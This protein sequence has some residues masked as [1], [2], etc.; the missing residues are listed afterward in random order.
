MSVTV[1]LADDHP[2]VRQGMRNLLNTEADFS[3]V[4]EAKNGLEAV[5]LGEQLRPDIMIVD[6]MMPHLNGL[7]VLRQLTGRLPNTRFIVLSMQSADPYVLQAL[8]AGASGYVLKDS[9]PEELIHAIRQVLNGNRYLSPQLNERMIRT[10][11]QFTDTGSLDPLATLTEREREV[12]K[13]TVEGL[14]S[15]EIG[16]KLS[17]SARTVETHRQNMMNKLDIKNQVDL[18]R[19]ALRHGIISMDD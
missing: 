15:A 4:G 2:V 8:K 11:I 19:F 18:I 14:T 12:L 13:M 16:E 3:V 1:L 7:E 5:Q 9:C 17:L 10:F 6:M